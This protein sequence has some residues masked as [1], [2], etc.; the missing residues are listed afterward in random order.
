MPYHPLSPWRTLIRAAILALL[1][2]AGAA[3]QPINES[4][5]TSQGTRVAKAQPDECYG[6]LGLNFPNAGPPCFF[7]QPKV[8]QSYPW[9]TTLDQSG[10]KVIIG[11]AAN[12]HCLGQARSGLTIPYE[13]KYRAWACEFG[14]SGWVFWT[15]LPAERG[16]YRPPHILVYDTQNQSLKDITPKA[17]G[18][19]FGFDPAIEET[20]GLRFSATFGG[21]ILIGGPTLNGEV[22]L[23]AFRADTLEYLGTKLFPEFRSVRKGA[24]IGGDLYLAMGATDGG[25][26]IRWTGQLG[27]SPC[28]NCFDYELVGEIDGFPAY[29]IEHE[30]RIAVSTWPTE[31]AFASIQ[32]S[33]PLNGLKLTSADASGWTKVFSM[34]EYEPDPV[35]AHTYA[36]GAMASF[37]GYL[38]FGTMHLPDL[39]LALFLE[40]YGAPSTQQDV[41]ATVLGV[42]RGSSLFRARNLASPQQEVDLLYGSAEFPVF[43]AGGGF[44]QWTLQPNLL[45]SGKRHP[46]FGL[47]GFWN[48]Y[49]QYVWDI[50][51]WKGRL[52]VGTFDYSLSFQDISVITRLAKATPGLDPSVVPTLEAG[53]GSLI[54]PIPND[55]GGDLWTTTHIDE[56]FL[57]EAR[58]GL[59]NAANWGVRNLLAVGDDMMAAM[60]NPANLLTDLFDNK[61]EGGWELVRLREPASNTPAGSDVEVSLGNG[62]EIRFCSVSAPG[63]TRAPKIGNFL[64]TAAYDENPLAAAMQTAPPETPNGFDAP[65][66]LFAGISTAEWRNS[67]GESTLADYCVPAPSGAPSAELRRLEYNESVLEWVPLPSVMDGGLV[68]GAIDDAALGIVGAFARNCDVDGNETVD[69]A[70]IQAI[71]AGRG[72]TALPGDARDADGDGSVTVLDARVCVV[73]CT[74]GGC[75]VPD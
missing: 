51:A 28:T 61:P 13:A 24:V 43:T 31:D 23:F 75:S 16:D 41:E 21:L 25:A 7:S 17:Q 63:V 18:T 57:P 64:Q 62:A 19:R 10:K 65:S 22:R 11:T 8:N 47:M 40:Q 50:K 29:I 27:A 6:L 30:D 55:G 46:K 34:D 37:G 36:G 74:S 26:V 42:Q 71:V 66:N 48:A 3:A 54:G 33:R 53:L 68:C 56:P 20:E 12:P 5:L 9:S 45:P 58:A 4:L 32:V 72:Q 60:A 44:G 67:C 70:D 38:V 49:N 39:G 35:L 52:L 73:R 59:G 69:A 2:I 14:L 15:G 1:C